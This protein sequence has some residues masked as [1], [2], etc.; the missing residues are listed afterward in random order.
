MD[1]QSATP[2]YTFATATGLALE[3]VFDG[4]RL[5][6]DGGLPW[7]AQADAVLGLCARLA[8]A[9]PER[10]TR[11]IRY[12][13]ESLVRQR[14]LQIACGY[15]DQNDAE[16]LRTDPLLKLVCGQL[17]E[18]GADLAGQSTFS[19]L[20]NSVGRHDC[21]RL[22][23]ALLDVYLAAREHDGVPRH[24][25]L[26]ID[27]TDDPTHGQQEG[28]AYHGYYRQHQYYPI[29]VFDGETDQLI[30]AILRPGTVHASRGLVTLLRVLVRELRQRWPGVAIEIRGDS[31]CAVPRVYQF[32]ERAHIALTYTLGLAG[33][34][35]LTK[36]AAP[37]LATAVAQRAASGAEKV[38]LFGETRY[39]AES[40]DQPRRVVYKAEALAKGPN[41]RFVVTTRTDPPDVLYAFYVDRGE[42]ELWIKDFKDA[43]VADRL[44][45]HR[46]W[47]NQCR[48]LLHAAA[49]WLLDTL[50]RWLAA[51]GLPPPQLDTLRLQLIKVGARVRE[52]TQRVRLHLAS[53][54]PSQALWALLCAAPLARHRPSP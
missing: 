12:S 1:P 45:D 26:D 23:H 20:E 34:P 32:C 51:C 40:W 39:Q 21:Q 37:L 44:S 50:R 35:R 46:F 7:L 24:I 28:A 29:L 41:V 42:P 6:S 8:G 16:T 53:S 49:Y 14:V 19:R 33:N 9:L 15:A 17:P 11:H 5:T 30:T 3:A 38:R 48:L 22:A 4:G 54:H 31:G 47:A 27:S 2:T 10:R 43:C 36:E 25:L 52:C 18:S 13:L